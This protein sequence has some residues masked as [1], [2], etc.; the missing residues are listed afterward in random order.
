LNDN[1]KL[2]KEDG[3][4]ATLIKE[5]SKIYETFPTLREK[6]SK[7]F[8]DLFNEKETFIVSKTTYLFEY[9]RNLIFRMIK[10]ELKGYQIQLEEEKK[11][12][13]ENCFNEQN[14][15]TKNIFKS[16]IRAFIVLF[17]NLE[18]DKE[19]NIKGNQNNIINYFDIQDIWDKATYSNR[20]FNKE[21]NNLKKINIKINQIL[22]L[23]DYLGE[24]INDEYFEE[25]K[26][27]IKAEEEIKKTEEKEE[28]PK[29][30]EN[31]TDNNDDSNDESS[32]KYER[33]SNEEDDGERDYV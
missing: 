3:R 7:G 12:L 11:T 30:E 28:Q 24:D 22:S 15:I 6:I 10:D 29:E 20:D 2:L 16:A 18:N 21:L 4:N 26:N 23:Y 32:D 31:P 19:N 14:L 17:L 25:V 8:T 1:K 33:K 13:I 27:S 9:Y 5:N